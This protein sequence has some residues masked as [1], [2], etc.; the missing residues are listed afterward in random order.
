M[1][2]SMNPN[3]IHIIEQFIEK[4]LDKVDWNSLSKN[5]NAIHLIKKNLDKVYWGYLS[6]N[7]S[8]FEWSRI[9][10]LYKKNIVKKVFIKDL[11]YNKNYYIKII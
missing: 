2:L 5:R 9:K 1:L 3:A 11:I 4:N 6:L 10:Y 7:P 8:I